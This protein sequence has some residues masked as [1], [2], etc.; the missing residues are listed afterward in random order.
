MTPLVGVL[1]A[2]FAV[3]L[4]ILL[5]VLGCRRILGSW[6]AAV[7]VAAPLAL[8]VPWTE[9]GVDGEPMGALVVSAAS[10]WL[11]GLVLTEAR[12]PSL[13]LVALLTVCGVAAIR[14]PAALVMLPALLVVLAVHNRIW[15]AAKPAAKCLLMPFAAVLVSGALAILL[16]PS[17]HAWYDDGICAP[18]QARLWYSSAHGEPFLKTDIPYNNWFY[19]PLVVCFTPLLITYRRDW[20]FAWTCLWAT[21]LFAGALAFGEPSHF[22]SSLPVQMALLVPFG[23]AGMKLLRQTTTGAVQSPG[24]RTPV[25]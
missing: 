23:I 22:Q 21:S 7:A 1:S 19:W 3:A 14:A 6:P 5:V 12:E 13:G 17:L 11:S 8:F 24:C 2:H 16:A 15:T 4:G 18:W 9:R 25:N 20:W 10:L